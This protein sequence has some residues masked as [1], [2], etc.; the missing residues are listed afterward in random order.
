MITRATASSA[1]SLDLK[2]KDIYQVWADRSLCIQYNNKNKRYIEHVERIVS[3]PT[4]GKHFSAVYDV[5]GSVTFFN[6]ETGQVVRVS[7]DGRFRLATTTRTRTGKYLAGLA[8]RKG[9]VFTRN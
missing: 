8:T 2:T 5:N 7:K 1:Y 6:S 9:R 3:R 4:S